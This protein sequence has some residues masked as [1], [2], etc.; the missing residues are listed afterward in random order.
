MFREPL[1]TTARPG[2]WGRLWLRFWATP[3]ML[4]GGV[5]KR[6]FWGQL[7][8]WGSRDKAKKEKNGVA[9]SIV[10]RVL[11]M[12]R[13]NDLQPNVTR[14]SVAC[15]VPCT[16]VCALYQT[17]NTLPHCSGGV[18]R[19]TPTMRRHTASGQWEVELLRCTTTLPA[20]SATPANAMPNCPG[21]V[22]VETAAMHCHTAR[23]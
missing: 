1:C 13:N 17:S 7:N 11:K 4:G 12:G 21:V 22:G 20:G 6:N 9:Q 8:H 18:G 2:G 23:G 16:A 5:E 19:G 3:Q 10:N 15:L 14:L